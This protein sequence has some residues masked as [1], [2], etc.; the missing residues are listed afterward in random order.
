MQQDSASSVPMSTR[1]ATGVA[2]F[3]AACRH[4]QPDATPIW[5]MRQAGRSSQGYQALRDKYDVLTLTKTPELCTQM[6][7]MPVQSFHVDGAVLYA[8]IML[9]LEGMG[10]DFELRTEGPVIHNPVRSARDVEAL[11]IMDIEESVP[12]ILSAIRLVR[13]ELE[14]KQAVIG[15]SGGPF[16][17]AC[18]LIEGKPSRDYATAKALMYSQPALWQRLM[19]K[20]STVVTNYLLAQIAAGAQVIQVFESWIGMLSPAMYRQFVLPY[21]QRIFAAVKQAGAPAIHF[22]TGTAALLEVLVE[23]GGDVISVDWRVELDQAWERIGLERG[24]QGNLDPTLLLTSWPVLEAGM[25]D[26]LRR[27]AN[28]SGHIFN[29]GHGIPAAADPGLLRQLVDAVHETTQR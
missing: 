26:V 21:T 9:P 16:T 24:I 2:R 7:L 10:I 5:F 18:Y 1:P 8:D 23:A 13:H 20:I 4:E 6:T 28:R 11:R 29:L 22:G 17:L 3:L 19:E 27:A 25:H 12:Y 15:V 14:G